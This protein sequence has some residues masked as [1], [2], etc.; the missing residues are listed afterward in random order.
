MR[1]RLQQLRV[2][3]PSK[4]IADTLWGVVSDWTPMTRDTV[5]KQL[6]RAADRIGANI[7]EGAGRG[8]YQDHRR[9]V[10]IA[11]GPLNETVDFL[12]PSQCRR[13]MMPEKTARLKPLFD[14]LGPKLNAY[15][16]SIAPSTG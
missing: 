14:E 8:T 11:R 13:P 4:S 6:V 15:L 10:R 1:P 5:G 9:F 12:R 2:Y 7:A 3:T 16:T